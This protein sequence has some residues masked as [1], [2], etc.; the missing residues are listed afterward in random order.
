MKKVYVATILGS[1]AAECANFGI[2]K[3]EKI[4]PMAWKKFQPQ[5][6]RHAKATI[7]LSPKSDCICL[8]FPITAMRPDTFQLFFAD[9]VF[10]IDTAGQLSDKIMLA[11]GTKNQTIVPGI[12]PLTIDEESMLLEVACLPDSMLFEAI[13]PDDMSCMYPL[14]KPSRQIMEKWLSFN[15]RLSFM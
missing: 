14:D 5:H 6:L 12:Y 10:R 13:S 15:E 1:P 7:S 2:C 8:E 11:L 9:G 3:V 4:S